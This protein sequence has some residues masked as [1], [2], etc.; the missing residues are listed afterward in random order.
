MKN[1]PFSN[2]KYQI[3]DLPGQCRSE[4]ACHHPASE[5]NAAP[6]R[7]GDK[8]HEPIKIEGE[9]PNEPKELKKLT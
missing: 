6:V 1:P 5:T 4:G 2:C 8:S 3:C 9:W 7:L